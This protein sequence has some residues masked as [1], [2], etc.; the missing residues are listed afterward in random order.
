MKLTVY[1]SGKGDCMLLESGGKR[2]LIDGGVPSSFREEVLPDL[3]KSKKKPLDCIY[4]SHIDDDHI[5]GLLALVDAIYEWRVFELRKGKKP[6]SKAPRDPEPPQVLK[7]WHNAFTDLLGENAAPVAAALAETSTILSGLDAPDSLEQEVRDIHDNLAESTRQALQLSFRVGADQ[8]G[9][10]VNPEYD[11]ELMFVQKKKPAL[12]LGKTTFTLLGP[13]DRDLDKLRQEWNDWLRKNRTTVTSLRSRARSDA[14]GLIASAD[15]FLRPMMTEASE[16][17]ASIIAKTLGDRKS[18]TTPNLASLMF[19]AEEGA[20]KVL[21][22]GDGHADDLLSGLEK[23]KKITPKGGLHLDV[24][25]VQHHGSEH[26]M[27]PDFA[28]RI[29]AD[30]YVFCGNGFSTNPEETVVDLL[31]RSRIGTDDERSS[32]PEVGRKFTFWFNSTPKSAQYA[33]QMRK[34]KKLTDSLVK[35]SKGQ[36]TAVFNDSKFVVL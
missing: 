6:P 27:T 18:V 24:L 30:H 13:F 2:M 34:V 1:P 16:L 12:K 11:G 14:G 7:I 20:R 4:L 9:I 35:Q 26:N 5:G 36:M 32:N 21:L 29:T 8:L 23:A 10:D 33:E 22:T 19:L 3:S 15:D 31:A 17:A 25:K 28:K